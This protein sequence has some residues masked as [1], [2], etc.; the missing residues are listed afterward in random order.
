LIKKIHILPAILIVITFAVIILVGCNKKEAAIT[1]PLQFTIPAGWPQPSEWFVNNPVNE[2]TFQLGRKLFYEGKLSKDGRFPCSS[3]HQPAASFTTYQHDRS[4]GYNNSHTLRNAPALLNVAWL[5]E[6]FWDG[7]QDHLYVAYTHITRNDEMGENIDSVIEK[8]KADTQYVRM[9]SNAFGDNKITSLRLL[10]ALEQF[11]AFIISNNSK[12]DKVMRGEAVFTV[13]EENGYNIF[14]AKCAVCHKE[15]L[16][17]D[18]SFRNTGLPVDPFL[19]DY[20]RMKVTGDKSDS[21]KFRVPGLRN[22]MVTSYYA[23]DGR[24]SD[25]GQM[26]QHYNSG[27]QKSAT[28]DP[29]LQNGIPLTANEMSYLITFM[30]ALTDNSVITNPRFQKP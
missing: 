24:F 13:A 2:E 16:F 23:H 18:N 3:C 8:L 12:Y 28:L 11:V 30:F 7:S 26:L 19:K 27:V 22:V 15:P 20:G 17:T 29:L 4:H 9:F 1:T 5:N 25:V 6:L 10:K 21:L 14:K